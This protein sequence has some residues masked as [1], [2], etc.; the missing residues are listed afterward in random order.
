L[1]ERDPDPAD[2]IIDVDEKDPFKEE[3][4]DESLDCDND[5]NEE[6]DIYKLM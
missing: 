6:D 3:E 5:E 2:H 4:E 1:G